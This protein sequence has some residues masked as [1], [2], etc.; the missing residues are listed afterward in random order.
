MLELGCGS[1]AASLCLA[2][3]IADCT[4]VGV[5]RDRAA[6]SLARANVAANDMAARIAVR[7]GDLSAWRDGEGGDFDHAFANPPF[8]APGS[9]TIATEPKEKSFVE[10]DDAPLARWLDEMIAAVRPK[11]RITLIHRAERLDEI[12]ARFET[13][14][15]A[16]TLFPLWP[17]TGRAAKRV[18]VSG[19]RGI[20]G[21]VTLAAGL[22][23]HNEDGA[24]SPRAQAILR[25][26]AAIDLSV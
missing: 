23:L 20:R 26:G 24:F 12:L 21:P 13:R 17:K 1:G 6:A 11:G 8:Y 15:G 9:Q 25:G 16:I 18:I 7:E 22:V 14:V 10:G 5:E 19:R 2:A 3:R 4:I